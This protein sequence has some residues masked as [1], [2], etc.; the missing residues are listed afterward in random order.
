MN[1]ILVNLKNWRILPFWFNHRIGMVVLFLKIFFWNL[2]WN[3]FW[4]FFI[5][6]FFFHL[7]GSWVV[8]R[9]LSWNFWISSFFLA[10]CCCW[11][12]CCS[13]G[14]WGN[15]CRRNLVYYCFWRIPTQRR[16]QCGTW[17]FFLKVIIPTIRR[18]G[19]YGDHYN[20]THRWFLEHWNSQKGI[21][22]VVHQIIEIGSKFCND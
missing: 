5:N 14:L 2:F 4:N 9:W 22:F 10:Y 13:S 16:C 20:I 8:W 18:I 12:C 3:L 11:P 6:C 7:S 1:L 15:S 21:I 17:Y 19:K